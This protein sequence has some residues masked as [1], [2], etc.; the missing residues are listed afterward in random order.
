MGI[1]LHP[2]HLKRYRDLAVLIAKYGRP[3]LVKQVGV[4]E[5]IDETEPTEP[6]DTD[7]KKLGE[8]L[9][10]DLEKMGPTYVKLGQLLSTRYDILPEAYCDALARLQDNVEPFPFEQVE[11]I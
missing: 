8:A 1:S 4:E 10:N 6:T 11:Q 9:A 5:A 2:E 7:P 3:G